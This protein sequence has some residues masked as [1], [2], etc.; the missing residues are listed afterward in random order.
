MRELTGKEEESSELI[1]FKEYN[2][3]V[4]VTETAARMLG[5]DKTSS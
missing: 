2:W 5:S 1:Y 3:Q 4:P